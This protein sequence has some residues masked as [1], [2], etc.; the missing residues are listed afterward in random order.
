MLGLNPFC[1]VG[2]Q[3]MEGSIISPFPD[4]S[5]IFDHM[6]K[7]HN[8]SPAW[9]NALLQGTF[10]PLPNQQ[11][12]IN[13]PK[14][15]PS[16]IGIWNMDLNQR[17]PGPFLICAHYSL[18]FTYEDIDH[19]QRTN[20]QICS[21]VYP[22]S[23][24]TAATLPR[25]LFCQLNL[26]NPQASNYNQK[27]TI[28][29]ENGNEYSHH[30][31]PAYTPKNYIPRYIYRDKNTK[32]IF[33]Q[34]SSNRYFSPWWKIQ[35]EKL[36]RQQ[37]EIP[38]STHESIIQAH[39]W[40]KFANLNSEHCPHLLNPSTCQNCYYYTA[41]IWALT[42]QHW[43]SK[44]HQRKEFTLLNPWDKRS[45]AAY[46]E[47]FFTINFGSSAIGCYIMTSAHSLEPWCYNIL[48]PSS[49]QG[50][51]RM[52]PNE[53]M[54]IFDKDN[55]T[56]QELINID[57]LIYTQSY[58]R[59]NNLILVPSTTKTS[60]LPNMDEFNTK[61]AALLGFTKPMPAPSSHESQIRGIK[62]KR[63]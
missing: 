22:L 8:F 41:A 57:G 35:L 40:N 39:A 52:L 2:L 62:R 23:D 58:D 54:V 6:R 26:E 28:I 63:K 61:K 20:K 43:L 7:I 9:K 19:S 49:D 51:L 3:A 36:A 18:C 10:I 60:L 48:P 17:T 32:K 33:K 42:W 11:V 24:T 50:T 59:N 16:M 21:S 31:N 1:I 13:I 12:P 15:R 27:A 53:Y 56:Q 46:P 47:G 34:H 37:K 55:P 4:L 45:H 38:L 44:L 14:Q 30:N 25:G 29:D 5:S